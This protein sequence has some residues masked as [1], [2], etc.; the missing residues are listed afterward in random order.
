MRDV[1]ADP[2]PQIEPEVLTSAYEALRQRVLGNPQTS[3]SVGGLILLVQKGL[4]VWIK[5]CHPGRP[6]R[7]PRSDGGPSVFSLESHTHRELTRLLAG[8]ALSTGAKEI[9]T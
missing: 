1:L 9:R 2:E 3:A 5:A 7:P 8:M 4:A 6:A